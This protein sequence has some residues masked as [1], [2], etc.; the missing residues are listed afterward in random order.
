MQNRIVLLS[1]SAALA[2]VSVPVLANKGQSGA[3]KSHAPATFKSS[4]VKTSGPKTPHASAP[5]TTTTTT[6]KNTHAPKPKTTTTSTTSAKGGGSKKNTSTAN[7]TTTA[8]TTSTSSTLGTFTPTNP[9]AQKLST[10]SNLLT[11]ARTTL[12]A[13]TDLNLATVGFKN[14][15][16]FVAAMNVSRNLNIPFSQLKA[17]MTGTNLAGVSTGTGV[18]SSLG[19]A[20]Q[21][22]K[23]TVNA[24]AEAAHAEAQAAMDIQSQ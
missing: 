11:R 16:Q 13:G 15:G 9:V 18:T 20:I 7:T 2:L 17:A 10:K 23:P 3:Q 14:F 19:Q 6:P 12:P 24:D 8:N 21:Q 1:L 5:K 22:L 4:S